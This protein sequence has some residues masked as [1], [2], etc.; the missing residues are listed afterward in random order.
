M[1]KDIRP[2]KDNMHNADW[3]NA[4]RNTAGPDYQSRVPEATQANVEQVINDLWQV[5]A[6][7]NQFIDGLINRI[8]M[9]LYKTL[10]WTNPLGKFK[11]GMLQYGETIEE[12]FFGLLQATTYDPNRDELEKEL[13]GAMTPEV[14]VSYHHIDRQDKYK[15]TVREPE[16]RK[17]F[18]SGGGVSEFMTGLMGMLQ[19]SDQLDEYL[20]MT[21]LFSIYDEKGGFFNE[22]VADLSDVSTATSD[23]ARLMLKKLR[24]YSNLLPFYSRNY[25]AAGMPSF[26]RPEELELFVTASA[27][28]EMDVDGLAAAFNIGKMEF[29]SRKTVLPD[30]AFGIDGAQAI[31]STRDLFVCADS[32]IETASMYNP[33]ALLNNYWLHHWGVYSMSRFAPAI[34]FSTRPSDTINGIVYT[35]ASVSA[36]VV[37]PYDRTTGTWSAAVTKVDRGQTY[38]V[39]SNAVTSPAGGPNDAVIYSIAAGTAGTPLSQFTYITNGGELIV[40][41]DEDNTSIIIT[42]T[43]VD[44]NTKTNTATVT[45][46]GAK[47]NPWPNPN[48]IPDSDDDG[49]LEVTPTKPDW[50]VAT[51]TI[52]IPT[53]E[54]VQYKNGATVLTNGQ[55]IV[56]ANGTPVTI[57]AV[58]FPTT[59][60]ELASGATASWTFTYNTP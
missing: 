55:Q 17:A 33:S 1:V 48:V 9:V 20:I 10:S 31:L 8:G 44:D 39:D 52:T 37:Y 59:G 32:R 2:L 15:L 25:N 40:G 3:L 51:N 7:R 30:A 60:Y 47:I 16:L 28:A 19:N 24:R 6:L 41:S 11:R 49:L 45:V 21:N 57:T 38:R 43:S 13:F 46:A 56:V 29:A 26:A 27:D 23:D 5:P 54:G 12:I 42:V 53:K 22:N 36:P 35:I 4:V 50:K 14:Q 18:L 34:L 58:A